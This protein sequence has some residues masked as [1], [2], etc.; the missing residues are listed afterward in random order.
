MRF[1]QPIKNKLFTDENELFSYV[2]VIVV[3]HVG[4]ILSLTLNFH[5]FMHPQQTLDH[6]QPIL[7]V[8]IRSK[9]DKTSWNITIKRLTY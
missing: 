6:L 5:I 8:K 9:Q 1:H 4:F 2:F 7:S 3:N